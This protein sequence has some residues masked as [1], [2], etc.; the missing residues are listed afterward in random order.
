MSV[1]AGGVR[2][3]RSRRGNDYEQLLNVVDLAMKDDQAATTLSSCDVIVPCSMSL[4][5]SLNFAPASADDAE[6]AS[7]AVTAAL[8]LGRPT[9]TTAR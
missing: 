7:V 4:I 3:D 6:T 2:G 8:D 1:S 9:R 5:P